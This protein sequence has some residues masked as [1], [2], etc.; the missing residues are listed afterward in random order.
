MSKP[1]IWKKKKDKYLKMSTAENFSQSAKCS[2]RQAKF[3]AHDIHFFFIFI[4]FYFCFLFFFFFTE[5]KF[6]HFM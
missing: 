4:L 1:I 3:V 2:K 5:N 6:G